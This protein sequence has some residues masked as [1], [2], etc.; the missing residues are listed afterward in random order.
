M[1][2]RISKPPV[3]SSR[4]KPSLFQNITDIDAEGWGDLDRL[5]RVRDD[6]A[7]RDYDELRWRRA[8]AR[9]KELPDGRMAVDLG[10]ALG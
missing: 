9:A 7:Q 5:A 3:Y 8:L 2:T 4:N 10:L 1:T 6:A